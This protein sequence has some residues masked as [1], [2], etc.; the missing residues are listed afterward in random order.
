MPP[1]D[2]PKPNT[3]EPTSEY[4]A[5]YRIGDQFQFLDCY[6]K[7]SLHSDRAGY[8]LL[9]AKDHLS[10]QHSWDS[11]TSGAAVKLPLPDSLYIPTTVS[12]KS[13]DEEGWTE[14][15]SQV[16]QRGG[17]L[18][19][20]GFAGMA[21][22]AQMLLQAGGQALG[23]KIAAAFLQSGVGKAI[24]RNAGVA[25]NPNKQM[26][27]EGKE[28]ESINVTFALVPR[29]SK[30]ANLM[31][32][33]CKALN[34]A[35]LP[36]GGGAASADVAG[37]FTKIAEAFAGPEAAQDATAS[38]GAMFGKIPGGQSIGQI[39]GST[40]F[41][42]YPNLWD[43]VVRIPYPDGDGSK[44]RTIFRWNSLAMTE[45][46]TQFGTNIKWHPDAL[47]TRIDLTL[48]FT[49]TI[50][51]VKGNLGDVMPNIIV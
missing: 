30:E 41:F 45:V 35:I 36:G 14:F 50:I 43:L 1:N 2:P 6:G 9:I 38:L 42:T 17:E 21:E 46:R 24:G 26:Y 48:A 39:L 32:T 16:M 12:W 8:V 23:R 27:L 49:E 40:P 18:N 15:A 37:L 13:E 19:R 3:K 22:N 5:Q 25:Y 11:Y 31:Y 34:Y 33:M 4:L 51:R 20:Q 10:G 29:N 44:E 7:G 47:P 28:F